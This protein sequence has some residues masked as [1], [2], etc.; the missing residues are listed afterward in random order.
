[1]KENEELL[2]QAAKTITRLLNEMAEVSGNETQVQ[3]NQ[4]K[5]MFVVSH[6]GVQV[7]IYSPEELIGEYYED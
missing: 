5:N 7:E 2:L 4:K 1:M 3:Y 6:P